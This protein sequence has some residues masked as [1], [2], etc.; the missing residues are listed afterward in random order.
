VNAKELFKQSHLA[1]T[2]IPFTIREL[3]YLSSSPCDIYIFE[4]D[5]F[6]ILLRKGAY[7]DGATLKDIISSGHTKVFTQESQRGKLIEI[8]QNNL[9]TITRS[10]SMGNPH[11]NCK[12]QLS[13]LALNLRYLFEDPTNDETL[14]LQYQ[15]LKILFQYLY[16]NPKKHE[17]I[18]KQFIKQGHHYIFTQPFISSLFLLGILKSSH[19]YSEKDIETLFITSYFKDIGMSAIPVEKYDIEDLNEHDKAILARHADLSVQ[20]LQGRLPV[21]PNHFKIIEAH[22]SFSLLRSSMDVPTQKNDLV[23]SGFETMMVNIT[24]IVAAMISP[25]PYREATSLFQALDLVKIMMANQYPQ[26]FKLI[27][28][29]FRSFFSNSVS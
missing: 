11:D 15:S 20:I 18:Y 1:L 27:V 22:H 25:R 6:K 10:F 8:Q 26:E 4:N 24:D 2:L 28:N 12:R 29:H 5:S 14:N 17:G 9:R 7:L 19:V 13:L 16:Q 3:F 23:V 21:S